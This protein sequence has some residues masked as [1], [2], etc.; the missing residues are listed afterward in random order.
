MTTSPYLN[1]PKSSWLNITQKLL[2]QHPLQPQLILDAALAT[3][4]TLWQTT[5]G[6]G[7]LSVRLAELRVPA[8]VVMDSAINR[9][10]HEGKIYQGP[11]TPE[12]RSTITLAD[13]PHRFSD[14]WPEI[15]AEVHTPLG[16]RWKAVSRRSR[17][18]AV[19]FR[20]E[21]AGIR[22]ATQT[23]N[24]IGLFDQAQHKRGGCGCHLGPNQRP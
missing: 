20:I 8:T 11:G 24:G 23:R 16:R 4:D 7:S 6:K 10:L 17:R 19:L 3:W 9:D 13:K 12:V 2:S 14:V 15:K 22:A 18:W 1:Q 21:T 5:L